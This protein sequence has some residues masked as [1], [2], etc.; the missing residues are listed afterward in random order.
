MY[1]HQGARR[2][3]AAVARR[4][5]DGA[6]DLV[7]QDHWR[8]QYGLTGRTVHPVVQ[9]RATDAAVGHL[10]DGL[11]GGRLAE[12]YRLDPEIV[13]CVRDDAEELVWQVHGSPCIE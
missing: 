8:P 10:D 3:A 1:R 2:R 4:L 12:R 7:A 13:G 9:V 5:H 11:V 6:D